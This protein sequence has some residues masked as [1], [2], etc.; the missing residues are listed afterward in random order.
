MRNVILEGHHVPTFLMVRFS[1]FAIAV[2]AMGGRF[3]I[4]EKTLEFPKNRFVFTDLPIKTAV[5]S[6]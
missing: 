4:K 3:Y 6:N 1:V 2:P 5:L